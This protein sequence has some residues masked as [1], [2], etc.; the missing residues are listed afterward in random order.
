MWFSFVRRVLLACGW[1]QKNNTNESTRE[2]C[3][4]SL[5]MF[6]GDTVQAEEILHS[7]AGF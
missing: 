2:K 6:D 7:Q 1:S 4:G 5:D 3:T